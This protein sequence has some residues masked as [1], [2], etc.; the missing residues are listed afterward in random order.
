[1]PRKSVTGFAEAA[2]KGGVPKNRVLNCLS[3]DEL[4][5]YLERRRA[6]RRAKPVRPQRAG[7]VTP[8][9]EERSKVIPSA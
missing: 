6:R 1:M 5:S 3:K 2:R 9:P 7:G 4:A 8:R